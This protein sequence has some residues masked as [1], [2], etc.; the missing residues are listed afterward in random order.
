ML[1]VWRL[2]KKGLDALNEILDKIF[3]KKRSFDQ[4]E[5]WSQKCATEVELDYKPKLNTNPDCFQ[6]VLTQRS[7][8]AV[9]RLLLRGCNC[10]SGALRFQIPFASTVLLRSGVIFQAFIQSDLS[11][12]KSA[13][14]SSAPAPAPVAEPTAAPLTLPKICSMTT[15]P[16]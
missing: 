10:G 4:G 6:L 2:C 12:H 14:A 15:E 9:P 5:T 3:N 1:N 13:P 8:G 11:V 16:M 7:V